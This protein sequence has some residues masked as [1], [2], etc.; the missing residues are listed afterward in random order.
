MTKKEFLSR[1]EQALSSLPKED[2]TERLAFYSEMLD[3]RMEEGLSEEEAISQIG[4]VKEIAAQIINEYSQPAAGQ[5]KHKRTL[6]AWEIVL[7]VLGSPL[8][9]SLLIAAF[10]VFLSVYIS[11]WSVVISLWAVEASLWGT[12]LGGILSGSAVIAFGNTPGGIA[13]LGAGL[14]CAGISVFLFYG[15]TAVTKGIVL[16]TKK[17]IPWI[18]SRFIQKEELSNEEIR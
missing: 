11:L 13:M 6:R 7:L 4:T 17:I 12:A 18:K 8:W 3:D 2:I 9:L 14:L 1:L 10:A 15:C 5:V 16:L